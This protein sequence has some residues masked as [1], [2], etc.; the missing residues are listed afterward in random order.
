MRAWWVPSPLWVCFLFYKIMGLDNQ[1]LKTLPVL[2]SLV[3]PPSSILAWLQTISES[4]GKANYPESEKISCVCLK[5]IDQNITR[6]CLGYIKLQS[7]SAENQGTISW[8]K[9][10]FIQVRA[11]SGHNFLGWLHN[12][13]RIYLFLHYW[14]LR[15]LCLEGMLCKQEWLTGI[16]LLLIFPGAR[17][18]LLVLLW[19]F[20]YATAL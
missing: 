13:I 7:Y 16:N 12:S 5:V 11:K 17:N 14:V 20:F 19:L 4:T 2:E 9:R 3:T 18:E 15:A 6:A 1:I 10:Y 8:R